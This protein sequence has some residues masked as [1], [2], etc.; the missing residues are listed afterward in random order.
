[1]TYS[2]AL[3]AALEIVTNAPVDKDES[4]AWIC[5]R[6]GTIESETGWRLIPPNLIRE[7]W[8]LAKT[9]IYENDQA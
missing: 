4:G 5:N 8:Q 3:L 1:M 7:A 9:L 2:Q 6:G